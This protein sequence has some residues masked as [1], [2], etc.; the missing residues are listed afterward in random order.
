MQI[1]MAGL[2]RM[3]INMTRRLLQ[4]GHRVVA[5]NRSQDKVRQIQSEG[6][7]GAASLADLV[8]RLDAPRV[9]WLMLPAGPVVDEHVTSLKGLLQEGDMVIDGGNTYFRDDIRHRDELAEKGVLFMDAGVSG[10]IWGLKLGYCTM[11]GGDRKVFE[12]VEPVLESLAPEDGYLY[13]GPTG[14]GHFVKMVHNGIEYGMMAAYAEGFEILK[15]S[16]YGD[17]LN[18]HDISHLWNQGSVIR[19]WLLE[20]AEDAFRED[21]DMSSVS[22]WVEDSGEGRWTLEQAVESGVSAPVIAASLF[23]RFRSRQRDPFAD[24]VL[25]ALRNKFGGHAVRRAGDEES[26]AQAGAGAGAVKAASADP[27][28][29]S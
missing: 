24:R 6:A 7:E 9:V 13:C 2:G 29:N 12:H 11:V 15:A 20:L 23:Q 27:E 19:S 3:G 14:S 1:G 16:R 17:E 25:A 5:C 8:S 4:N 10:G 18:F 21:P 26:T 22:G 28:A